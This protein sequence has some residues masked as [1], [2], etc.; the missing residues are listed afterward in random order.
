MTDKDISSHYYV[1]AYYFEHTGQLDSAV[2]YNKR[3]MIYSNN[4]E[5]K[6]ACQDLIRILNKREFGIIILCNKPAFINDVNIE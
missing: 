6:D 5:K 4:T 2:A 3:G 1:W